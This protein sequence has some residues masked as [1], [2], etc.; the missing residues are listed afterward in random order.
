[1]SAPINS[2]LAGLAARL[3]PRGLTQLAGA[4]LVSQIATLLAMPVIARLVGANELGFFQA[5][6]TVTTFA[7]VLACLRF[8]YA[9]LQPEDEATAARL[10]SVAIGCAF[11]T[12]SITALLIPSA[13][14]V[15]QTAAWRG[16]SSLALATGLA[17]SIAGFN[18][19]VS[20]WMV[21][22]GA[23]A[24]LSRA[25]WIQGISTVIL[26]VG[27]AAAGWGAPGLILSD[28]AGRV[29]GAIALAWSNQSPLLFSWNLPCLRMLGRTAQD[30]LRF[31]VVSGTSSFVSAIGFS[32]PA[33]VIE[34]YFGVGALGIYSLV[35]RVMGIPTTLIG[36]PLA[37]T[38]AH[39]FK[40]AMQAGPA[41]AAA[42]IRTTSR[43]AFWLGL[44]A[45]GTLACF[46]GPLFTLIFGASWRDAGL[47]AQLLTLPYAIAYS[48]WP[49][50]VTLTILNRLRLQL[51]WDIGRSLAML[52]LLAL[53]S[54]GVSSFPAV[55]SAAVGL[56]AGFGGLHYWLCI[57][58]AA[59]HI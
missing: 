41:Q 55:M 20:Q 16:L 4:N 3:L 17:V 30:F 48:V 9:I 43:L 32:L 46:G 53:A 11:V 10:T 37:Q 56:I 26:Q 54:S 42:E 34:R 14:S 51:A 1:M 22:H 36:V 52:A 40:L 39:R 28:V 33:F 6:L 12:G 45:F 57:R 44:P 15:F 47:L 18:S 35:E 19:A 5:Y 50:M 25:R 13:A 24:G 8:E 49:V 21:R 2:R 23:F 38:F 29:A 7:G 58:C 31:P 59:H 27:A